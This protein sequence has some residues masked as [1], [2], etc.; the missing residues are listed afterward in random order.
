MD[1]D[2]FFLI[3]KAKGDLIFDKWGK[4][5]VDCTSQGW[6]ASI[7]HSHSR[8]KSAV[9]SAIEKDLICIRPSYYT[10]PKLQL[11]EKITT[12]AP[13]N[14][15]KINFCLHGS[16]AVEGAIKLALKKSRNAPFVVLDT[17]FCGRSIVTGALS[18][19]YYLKPEF[20]KFKNEVIRVPSPYCYRCPFNKKY[21]SCSFECV[22]VAD[23]VFKKHKPV[24][25]IYEAIQGNGGQINFPP[26]YHKLM[27]DICSINSV[28][29]ISDEIQTNF[30]KLDKI[31]ASNYYGIKPDIVL[32][33]KALG[34]GFP[35]AATLYGEG[36]DFEGG[37]QTFT[38]AS[39]PLSMVAALE[40][41][42]VI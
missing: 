33:G 37:D 22:E 2:R 35:L 26:E 29:M 20:S 14:L 41:I 1:V 5:Y 23:S 38:H 6:V 19:D 30:G 21:G 11:A 40:T 24:A 36:L 9:I 15:T 42:S 28:L 39:F 32:I 13:S 17:G 7:G 27:R 31:F 34:G 16:I 4:E 18:W 25:F 10:I 12:I 3:D 8:I